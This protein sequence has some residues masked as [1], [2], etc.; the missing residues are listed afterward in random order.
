MP[1]TTWSQQR[2]M[3]QPKTTSFANVYKT[4]SVNSSSNLSRFFG[5]INNRVTMQVNSS[6]TDDANL[7]HPSNNLG[8]PNAQQP[9]N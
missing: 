3:V 6:G 9:P 5:R 8:E 2:N 4:G 7:P 1:S